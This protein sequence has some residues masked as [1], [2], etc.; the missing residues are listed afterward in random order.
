MSE[1]LHYIRDRGF[2][3]SVWIPAFA[4]TTAIS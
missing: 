1:V 2:E 4:G 3:S